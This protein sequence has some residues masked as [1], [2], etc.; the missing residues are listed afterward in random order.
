MNGPLEGIGKDEKLLLVCIKGK[1]G[2]FLQNRLKAYG[3]T[4]TK[5]LEGATFFND[6]KVKGVKATVSPEEIMRVKGLG[7]L[8]DKNTPDCFNARVIT[9]NGK[10]TADEMAAITGGRAEVWKRRGDHDHP[11]DHGDSEDSL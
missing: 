1:R 8:R 7:F 4:N 6:V 10:V 3:Y 11:P 5:V 2:Y 9:R